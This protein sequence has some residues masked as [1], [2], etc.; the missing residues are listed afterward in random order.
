MVKLNIELG[1]LESAN[2]KM[3][4]YVIDNA[5]RMKMILDTYVLGENGY[6][7]KA[8]SIDSDETSFGLEDVNFQ[9]LHQIAFLKI[10]LTFDGSIL[11]NLAKSYSGE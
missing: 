11:I 3:R 4:E 6:L 9:K 5:I 1:N 8:L 10:F 7:I 2:T